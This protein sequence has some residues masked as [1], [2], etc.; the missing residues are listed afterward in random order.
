MAKKRDRKIFDAVQELDEEDAIA[1]TKQKASSKR[2]KQASLA[3]IAQQKIQTNLVQVRILL[4]RALQ[5]DISEDEDTNEAAVNE[6]NDLLTQLLAARETLEHPGEGTSS[7]DLKELIQPGNKDQLEEKLAKDF[8]KCQKDWESIFN[9]RHKD[10]RLHAGLTSSK[11]QF[12]VLDNSFWEQVEQTVS[13]EE[14]MMQSHESPEELGK[15]QFDDSKVYQQLLKDFLSV[16][17]SDSKTGGSST[18]KTLGPTGRLS[19]RTV[20]KVD[21]RASKG[22]KLRYT[23]IPKLVNFT[24]PLSRPST[25]MLDE[26]AWFRSMFGGAAS[27]K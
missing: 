2:Q 11:N 12:R 22:R 1:L 26:D 6:C 18:T 13:H 21:R 7:N 5:T 8:E 14:L 20:N 3:A 19:V 24:F 17:N 15:K 16:S 10:V 23:P 25:G 27:K 4:Q 9:Q